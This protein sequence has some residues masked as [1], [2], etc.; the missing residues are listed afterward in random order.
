MPPVTL[1]L[2]LHSTSALDVELEDKVLR[3][4]AAEH[5]TLISVAHRATAIRHHTH[6]LVLDGK[7]GSIFRPIPKLPSS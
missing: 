4:A 5:I 6:A 3:M 1:A 7:G 2:F